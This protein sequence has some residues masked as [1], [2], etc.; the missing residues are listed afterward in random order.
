MKKKSLHKNLET[1]AFEVGH[2]EIMEEEKEVE[3]DEGHDQKE[4]SM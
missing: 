2:Q 3:T 4:E 1:R